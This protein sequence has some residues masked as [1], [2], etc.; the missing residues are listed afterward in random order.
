MKYGKDNYCSI[1][2]VDFVNIVC[3]GFNVDCEG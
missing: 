1:F 3:I 2:N